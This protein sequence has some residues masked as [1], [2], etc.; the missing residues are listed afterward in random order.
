M[1]WAFFASNYVMVSALGCS[2]GTLEEEEEERKN[3]LLLN[4][5]DSH[6]CSKNTIIQKYT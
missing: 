5:T 2:C 1:T 6:N 3:I 4:L